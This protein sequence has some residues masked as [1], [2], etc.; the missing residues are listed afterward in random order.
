[1]KKIFLSIVV[2]LSSQILFATEW[3]E[4]DKSESPYFK[5]TGGRTGDFQLV[6]TNVDVKINGIIAEVVVTQSYQHSGVNVLDANYLF[7]ASN[8]AAVHGMTLDI[9]DRRIEAK[10]E[11]KQSAREKYKQAL[12]EG[13]SAALLEQTRPNLFSFAAGNIM[14]GDRVK[15][16]L[17]YTEYLAGR[18]G[19][20]DFYFPTVVG[21]RY[22]NLET[23]ATPIKFEN[24]TIQILL[25]SGGEIFEPVTNWHSKL[26]SLGNQVNVFASQNAEQ[27]A[28]QK[29]DF[30]FSFRLANAEFS[31]S[32][33][34]YQDDEDNYFL[35]MLHPPK[36]YAKDEILAQDFIFVMDVSGSMSG[37]PLEL[38]KELMRT[39]L[40]QM[41]PIDR[42]NVVQFAGGSHLLFDENK[43]ASVSR[44]EDALEFVEQPQG[45]GGT[46]VLPALEN[47]FSL[48]KDDNRSYNVVIIT[49]GLVTVERE[50]FDM[51]RDYRD[52]ANV[53]AFGTGVYGD[54][55]YL[56][57][58]IAHSAG[59]EAFII[60][61][62]QVDKYITAFSEYLSTPL[63]TNVKVDY[64]GL[65]VSEVFPEMAQDIFTQ[66][67]L[68]ISGKYHGELPD[69]IEFRGDSIS[70]T[71][72]D[73]VPVANHEE[74]S[75]NQ[76]NSQAIKYLWAREKIRN[77][78]DYQR[79]KEDSE[80]EE[81]I[82]TLGLKY[83]LLTKY[84]SFIAI[85]DLQRAPARPSDYKNITITG[86][87]IASG[88][89]SDDIDFEPIRIASLEKDLSY[90]NVEK[91][92]W[93]ASC[94]ASKH[95]IVSKGSSQW[96]FLSQQLPNKFS[97]N[98]KIC[99]PSLVIE[100][101]S[102]KNVI[103]EQGVWTMIKE[104]FLA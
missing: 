81:V 94:V 56:F 64:N 44:V 87:R 54:N 88:A 35:A 20:Y 80:T 74:S 83:N 57:D 37:R 78:S 69:S 55:K 1:M 100:V 98:K 39:L 90:W 97:S 12:S 93:V 103:I 5:V 16:E 89:A 95:V 58:G 65:E 62:K 4:I 26:E 43:A 27:N 21:P 73:R 92:Q 14:P 85:D 25:Q 10:I 36:R 70:G 29:H 53:F 99:L 96:V 67:P 38:S 23:A 49:D 32:F 61:D 40:N 9:N 104:Y 42:F 75:V 22:G 30:K 8:R 41:R 6:N 46:E 77:L 51:V 72:S 68:I 13:K 11:R 2:V 50:V 33:I 86:S 91:S 82:T 24:T 52:K 31:S 66:R 17:R 63:L 76:A 15:V 101:T 18:K 84:T 34:T 79:I 45:G 48:I 71:W 3:L 59:T 60:M 102:R 19:L 7:P 47:A 28:E